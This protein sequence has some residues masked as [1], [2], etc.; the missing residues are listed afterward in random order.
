[1]NPILHGVGINGFRGIRKTKRPINLKRFNVVRY[2]QISRSFTILAFSWAK[3]PMTVFTMP[4]STRVPIEHTSTSDNWKR[5]R[6]ADWRRK[7]GWTSAMR[8][9]HSSV[10][11]THYRVF[12]AGSGIPDLLPISPKMSRFMP[13]SKETTSAHLSQC[14]FT[15]KLLN[16][17]L[18]QGWQS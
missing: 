7:S 14:Y 13:V 1:M 8:L 12:K 17:I 15:R 4:H 6:D 11:Q 5:N 16:W 18:R 9:F 3:G 2:L 10:G